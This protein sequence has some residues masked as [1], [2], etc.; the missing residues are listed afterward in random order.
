MDNNVVVYDNYYSQLIINSYY[1]SLSVYLFRLQR[2]TVATSGGSVLLPVW[3]ETSNQGCTHG[4]STH[5]DRSY[6]RTQHSTLDEIKENV[7]KMSPKAAIKAV[8]DK[9]GGIV[10]SKTLK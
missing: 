4:N 1:N 3:R 5:T 8:Y 2:E 10:N 9:A 7:I 6:I